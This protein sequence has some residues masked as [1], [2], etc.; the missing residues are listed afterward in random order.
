M[1]GKINPV[2]PEVV[3]QVCYYVIGADTTLTMACEAG[4]LQLNVMEPVIAFS[5]FSSFEYMI[6]ACHTLSTKCIPGITANR[7]ICESH[8]MN[9]VGIVTALNPILGYEKTSEVARVALQTGKTVHQIAV[10]EMKLITQEKWNEIYSIENM[11]NP[12]FIV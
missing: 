11:I 12:K 9:S 3:N 10:V 4:Q 7:E 8:V 2:I 6:N 5:M 1:P